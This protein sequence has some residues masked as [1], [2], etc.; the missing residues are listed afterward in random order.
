MSDPIL[1]LGQEYEPEV[2]WSFAIIDGGGWAKCFPG[3]TPALPND[4]FRWVFS[5]AKE[6][7]MA[8]RFFKKTRDPVERSLQQELENA[9]AGGCGSVWLVDHNIDLIRYWVNPNMKTEEQEV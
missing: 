6:A 3:G 5:T 2:V 1:G 8:R 7:E 4:V 9:W